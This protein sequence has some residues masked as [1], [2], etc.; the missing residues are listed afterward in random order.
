MLISTTAPLLAKYL[1][2]TMN[3]NGPFSSAAAH[4]VPSW[5][6]FTVNPSLRV[7]VGPTPT[8]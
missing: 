7:S 2:G 3:S 4:P 5:N 8:T 6:P 1:K